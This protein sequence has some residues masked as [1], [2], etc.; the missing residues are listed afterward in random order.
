MFIIEAWL[1]TAPT[2]GPVTAVVKKNGAV[3]ATVAIAAGDYRFPQTLVEVALEPTDYLTVD[4]TTV[5]TTVKGKNLTIRM[6]HA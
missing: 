3:I 1:S 2:G 6:I 4:I 5:G